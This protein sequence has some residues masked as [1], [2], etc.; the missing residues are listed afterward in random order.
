MR[1]L[2]SLFLLL[3]TIFVEA[4]ELALFNKDGSWGYLNREGKVVADGFEKAK[5]FNDD[6]AGVMKDGKWGFINRSGQMIIE[7]QF[8]NARDFHAGIALIHQDGEW[9]YI[10]KQGKILDHFPTKDKVY[11]FT[12]N[13]R[14]I[15]RDGDK[16]GIMDTEGNIIVEPQYQEIKAY[17]HGYA[18]VKNDN[19]WGY[20]D[21]SGKVVVDIEYID[22]G[23]MRNGVVWGMKKKKEYGVIKNNKFVV[24][25]GVTDMLNFDEN[26][27]A[28]AKKKKKVGHVNGD[29]EWIT[30]PKY[31]AVKGFYDGIADRKSIV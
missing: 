1:V 7:P 2:L 10:N 23:R 6:A 30:E 3:S 24:L 17:K 5:E 8:D 26:G 29:G 20:I 18:K 14:A 15:L 12:D 25:D 4:Q 13:G 22:L 11:G 16:I 31:K 19:K 28:P 9:K 21:E 27:I